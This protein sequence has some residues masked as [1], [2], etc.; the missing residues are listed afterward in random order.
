MVKIK[1]PLSKRCLKIKQRICL[2]KKRKTRSRFKKRRIKRKK[3][4]PKS[5]IMKEYADSLDNFDYYENQNENEKQNFY[6]IEVDKEQSD[7]KRDSTKE[8]QAEIKSEN[9]TKETSE[10]TDTNINSNKDKAPNDFIKLTTFSQ[11][12]N[13]KTDENI[14]EIKL[15]LDNESQE[16]DEK[17]DEL[18]KIE[19]PQDS[20]DRNDA[21]REENNV[22]ESTGQ[23][24]LIYWEEMGLNLFEEL[25]ENEYDDSDEIL[26]DFDFLEINCNQINQRNNFPVHLFPEIQT[27]SIIFRGGGPLEF[28]S[29]MM[30]QTES[31]TKDKVP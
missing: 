22:N 20:I 12:K 7:E 5:K 21:E 23:R 2:R 17:K 24:E 18:K 6:D 30:A 9:E 25:R 10:K 3:N 4:P 29:L 19:S 8:T 31:C 26:H 28:S 14:K 15:S 16:I 13:K 11:N 1:I 27:E